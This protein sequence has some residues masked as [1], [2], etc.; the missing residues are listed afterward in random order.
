MKVEDGEL[1]ER[2]QSRLEEA[3]KHVA[4]AIVQARWTGA[5]AL[6]PVLGGAFRISH[7]PWY[8]VA[9][10]AGGVAVVLAV[11]G[12]VVLG[13]DVDLAYVVARAERRAR[14]RTRLGAASAVCLLVAAVAVVIGAIGES[15]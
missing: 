9:M 6:G 13:A 15:E 1:S 14:V 10:V 8:V 4:S 12:G 5:L 11:V 2:E 7:G 3:D